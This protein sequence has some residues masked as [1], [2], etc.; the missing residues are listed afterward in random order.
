MNELKALEKQIQFQGLDYSKYKNFDFRKH[1]V[2]INYDFIKEILTNQYLTSQHFLFFMNVFSHYFDDKLV[3]LDPYMF[4]QDYMPELVTGFVLKNVGFQQFEE[5]KP[6]Q[7]QKQEELFS[8]KQQIIFKAEQEQVKQSLIQSSQQKQLEEYKSQLIQKQEFQT[9]SDKK[10]NNGK[11]EP[12]YVKLSQIQSSQ[13]KQNIQKQQNQ[14]QNQQINNMQQTQ[15]NTKVQKKDQQ[16]TSVKGQNNSKVLQVQSAVISKREKEET[17]PKI[18][19]SLVLK[20]PDL[21]NTKPQIQDGIEKQQKQ[22]QTVQYV[23]VKHNQIQKQEQTQKEPEQNQ[24]TLDIL[25]NRYNFQNNNQLVVQQNLQTKSK[26]QIEEENQR[27]LQ[28]QARSGKLSKI[29]KELKSYY[30]F[31]QNPFQETGVSFIPINITNS[32][33]ICSIIFPEKQIIQYCDSLDN[34]DIRIEEGLLQLANHSGEIIKWKF[35]YESPKQSNNYDCGVFCLRALY[36][37]MKTKQPIKKDDYSQRSVSQFR[38]NLAKLSI[39]TSQIDITQQ[40]VIQ[41]LEQD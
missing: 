31:Q 20:K 21:S 34:R 4:S 32:H 37:V 17:T 7:I 33:W 26:Q 27:H 30:N 40:Q 2:T 35:V 16:N 3:Y 29:F 23:D 22:Q 19:Q 15:A 36:Q 24:G 39:I 41:I 14:K 1:G 10:Q 9:S 38:K 13:Q 8:D 28:E 6:Q 12:E 5:Q 25:D 11:A 18:P